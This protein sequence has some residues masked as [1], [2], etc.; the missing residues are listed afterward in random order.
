MSIN[1]CDYC[2]GKP[3]HAMS[4]KPVLISFWGSS[5]LVWDCLFLFFSY[6]KPYV[7]LFREKVRAIEQA[8]SSLESG[9]R[10][11]ITFIVVQKRHHTR[12][13]QPNRVD[14]DKSGNVHPGTV[15]E[16]GIC[17]PMEW[18][19]YLMSHGGLQGTSRPAKYH[20]LWDGEWSFGIIRGLDFRLL[21]DFL[22][23]NRLQTCFVYMGF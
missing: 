13:F 15:V 14:Q 10:P 21:E 9:Y 8:C 6:P 20:V 18:D 17:H 5:F 2:D 16:T 11:S 1:V 23:P 7:V 3:C 12:L 19:F 4:W 22:I